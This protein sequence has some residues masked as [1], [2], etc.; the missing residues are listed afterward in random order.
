MIGPG[1]GIA[2][3]IATPPFETDLTQTSGQLTSHADNHAS[4]ATTANDAS[5]QDTA[6]RLI[7][8]ISS[9]EEIIL[10]K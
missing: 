3:L 4:A 2:G 6:S 1:D 5:P 10:R 9:T 7:T 8:P